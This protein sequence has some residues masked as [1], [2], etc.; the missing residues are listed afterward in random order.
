[1]K[2]RFLLILAVLT[3]IL[4]FDLLPDTIPVIGWLDDI[5]SV[6]LILQELVGYVRQRQLASNLR[7]R[8]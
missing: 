7:I 2:K 1:M 3:L 8:K 5:A 6:L 4:P